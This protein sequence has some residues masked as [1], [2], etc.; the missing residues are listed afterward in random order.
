MC[1]YK[2]PSVFIVYSSITMLVY[3]TVMLIAASDYS[4]ILCSSM[5]FIE[6]KD[7]PAPFCTL[8]GQKDSSVI[9]LVS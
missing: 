3:S 1:R 2:I 9:H 4:K 5:D 6:S 8:T 7:N